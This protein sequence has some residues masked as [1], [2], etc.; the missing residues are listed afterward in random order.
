M[1]LPDAQLDWKLPGDAPF[2]EYPMGLAEAQL[3]WKLSGDAPSRE[4]AW[5]PSGTQLDL[6]IFGYVLV[7]LGILSGGPEGQGGYAPPFLEGA[8]AGQRGECEGEEGRGGQ[9]PSR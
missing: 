6:Y 8:S 4:G 5:G 2:R 1:G 3:D 7:D 9:M